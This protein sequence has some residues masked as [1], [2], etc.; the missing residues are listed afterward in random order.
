MLDDEAEPDAAGASDDE[1]IHLDAV[2]AI[3]DD[4]PPYASPAEAEE[5]VA[6]AVVFIGV[7]SIS[8]Y[9]SGNSEAV[10]RRTNHASIHRC[11]L[12]RASAG[13]DDDLAQG[14]PVGLLAAWLLR[15]DVGVPEPADRGE[16]LSLFCVSA[17]GHESRKH[18]RAVVAGLEGG[19]ALLSHERPR[20]LGVTSEPN[21]PT[22]FVS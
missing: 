10:F 2:L 12:T 8:Y 4:C 11:R 14:R 21:D 17:L 15:R 20:R 1:H 7:H 5:G 9:R 19:L 6:I 3:E 16:H 18:V 22:S 13:S